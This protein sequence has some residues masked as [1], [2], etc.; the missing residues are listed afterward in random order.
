MLGNSRN[1]NATVLFL[2]YEMSRL[3]KSME[4]GSRLVVARDRGRGG[5]GVVTGKG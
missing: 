4:T 2:F 3:S 5:C 1:L